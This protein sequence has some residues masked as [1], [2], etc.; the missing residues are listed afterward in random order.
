MKAQRCTKVRRIIE[1]GLFYAELNELFTR[2][3]AADGYGGCEVRTTPS[4]TEIIIK[5]SNTKLF[6]DNNGRRLQEIRM[7]VLK[8]WHIKDD[9]LEIFIDRIQRRGLSALNQLESLRFKLVNRIPA[10]RAAYSIIRFVMD[11]GARGCEV[12]ISGKMR[13]ARAAAMKFREGYMVKSGDVSQKYVLKAV[14]HIPMKQ[15]VVGI[16][17]LIML[18]HD[19]QGITGPREPQ[20]D[21]IKV[22]EAKD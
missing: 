17:V 15:A 11:A 21:V 22:H 10:R 5:A 20:P 9:Q 2:E 19:P 16:R 13:S 1:T 12:V 4:R 18:A 7:M 14:G 3:L 6:V 8:R